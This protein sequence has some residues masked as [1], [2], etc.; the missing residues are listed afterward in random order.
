MKVISVRQPWAWLLFNGKPV[1]NRDWPCS[2]RG[3]LAIHASAKMTYGEYEDAR[4]FVRTFDE[5]LCGLIPHPESLTY[6][7]VLGSVMMTG[8]FKEHSSPWF[9]GKWGHRYD[10][11]RLLSVPVLCRGALGLW[12]PG[13]EVRTAILVQRGGE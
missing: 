11:P 5:T 2:Y 9:Q 12:E 7:A 4:D 6:G 8:C 3:V 10:D 13:S 1:E